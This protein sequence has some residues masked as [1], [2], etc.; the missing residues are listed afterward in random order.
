MSQLSERFSIFLNLPAAVSVIPP[1]HPS[2][3]STAMLRSAVL[4]GRK[5][6]CKAKAWPLRLPSSDTPHQSFVPN[7]SK[8][9]RGEGKSVMAQ[10]FYH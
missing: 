5:M 4:Y 2:M 7:H 3:L 6:T 1:A 10:T 8:K 9:K